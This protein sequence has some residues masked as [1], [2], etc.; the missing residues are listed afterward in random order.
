MD[1]YVSTKVSIVF[2]TPTSPP[3]ERKEGPLLD[4]KWDKEVEGHCAYGITVGVIVETAG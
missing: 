1:A 4:W 2:Q 3:P